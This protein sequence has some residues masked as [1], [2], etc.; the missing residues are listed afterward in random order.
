VDFKGLA[1]LTWRSDAPA[2]S[3]QATFSRFGVVD[4]DGD[5]TLPSAFQDGQR[6][7]MVWAHQWTEPVGDGT[8]RVLSDRAVFEGQFWTDTIDGEQA[9]KKVKRAGDLQEYSYGFAIR[10][11]AP[12]THD[13]QPVR[14]L[15][16]LEVFEVSPVLVGAGIG[17]GT[18][19]IKQATEDALEEK[20]YPNEHSCRIHPV[21][22]YDRFRRS[23]NDRQHDGKRVDVIY[24]HPR[25]GGGWEQQS[26]R[27]P[28]SA[29][30]AAAARSYCASQ[31]G[32]FE[33]A[34]SHDHV[35]IAD[36]VAELGEVK[37]GRRFSSASR[38]E[39]Q[40]AID[41]LAALIREVAADEE[42]EPKAATAAHA[43]LVTGLG[44]GWLDQYR[45]RYRLGG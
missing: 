18:D 26:L 36:L 21:E 30:D 11:A 22:R 4:R 29:W 12:G 13:G 10:D 25:A 27:L 9:W 8:I 38:R 44:P 3:L 1:D 28:T 40:A 34:K 35:L 20:P 5:L 15:K 14:V 32:A 39:I 16:S 19:R 6:V 42:E 41:A 17:T 43:A 31:D 37:V 24:G 7:P 2:G 33:A 45:V 23:N